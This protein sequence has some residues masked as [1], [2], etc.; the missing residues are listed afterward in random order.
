MLANN[1]ANGSS[2]GFKVD[3]AFYS[4]FTGSSAF[5]D[6]DP[7][8]AD[9][10]VIEKKWTDFSQGSLATTG[11]RTDMALSG[12]G[13]FAVNGPN[14]PL[15]TRNGAFRISA[16]GTL[17]TAEGYNVRQVQVGVQQPIPPPIQLVQG[18]GPVEVSPLGELTQDGQPIAQLEID[19]FADPNLLTKG[20][21]AYFQNPDPKTITPALAADV[22][23]WQGKLEASNSSAAESSAGMISML[24]HFDMLNRAVKLATEMNKEALDEVARIP[25]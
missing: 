12:D 18:N 3:R 22:E 6:M 9:E 8:V 1:I 2:S 10:P 17:V 15:Y 14:G 20:A 4:T 13:F 23:V 16:T 7:S 19:T 11:S 25:T 21:A 24:R 5:A